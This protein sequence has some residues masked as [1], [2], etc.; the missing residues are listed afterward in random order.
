VKLVIS[1]GRELTVYDMTGPCQFDRRR[2]AG[3]PLFSPT[4]S[5][6]PNWLPE[7]TETI[8]VANMVV[9]ACIGF[10][11]GG[12]PQELFLS[13]AKD[14]SSMAAILEDA[15]DVI[16]VALQHGLS[17]RALAKSVARLLA[18]P[19]APPYLDQPSGT[20]AAA[21]II[22]TA[23]D[24]IAKYK[25]AAERSSAQEE[26]NVLAVP[27]TQ[28]TTLDLSH[29]TPHFRDA[30]R[31]RLKRRGRGLVDSHRNER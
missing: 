20:R 4:R 13:V 26:P 5:R 30:E 28:A 7:V 11:L 29:T 19:L 16:A 12:R 3:D 17:A 10:G 21:S 6:L 22:G 15:S 24:L 2:G 25:V 31:R 18:A 14:G 8:V 1:N 9:A 23:L 27:K